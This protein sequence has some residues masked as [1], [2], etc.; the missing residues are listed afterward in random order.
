MLPMRNKLLSFFLLLQLTGIAQ[1]SDGY[2]ELRELS[3]KEILPSDTTPFLSHRYSNGIHYLYPLY[4]AFYREQ[5]LFAKDSGAYYDELS[6][7]LA[8]A[9]DYASVLELE[10]KRM[11]LP[12]DIPYASIDTVTNVI[13]EYADA[14]KYILSRVKKQKVVMLNE[15]H[16]KPLHRA[17]ALSL[18]EDLYKEGFRYLAME[19]LYNY[20]NA[21][22]SVTAVRATTGYYTAEPMAGELVRK[23]LELGYTLVP[24]EDTDPGHTIKQREYT[25]A[26]HL[27]DFLKGKDSTAKMLV[28]AGY[29]HIEE[30]SLD[31]ARI[32]M[33][34][35]FK[36]ITGIDPFTID[37]TQL[38][39][40]STTPYAAV[41]YNTWIKKHPLTTASVILAGYEPFDL[42]GLHLFDL[43]VIHPPTRFSNGRPLWMA[44]NGMKKETP[45]AAPYRSVFMV[46]AYY[47]NEYSEKLVGQLVPSDQTY[48]SPNGL[49]YLYLQKGKYKLVFRDKLYNILGTKDLLSE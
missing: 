31:E 37:Q 9:S 14:H 17:F 29:G 39:E 18:L 38:S 36:I 21:S 49:Y 30:A 40:Y 26:Q 25:Q 23:A 8:T 33:A 28:L 5:Q 27:A 3:K 46:Q 4:K 19:M 16:N 2:R 10:K 24:Y 42:F 15:A 44:V 7:A 1:F 20:S 35:Y 13:S 41:V 22:A 48:N 6:Q 32:P 11:Y 12:D 47:D 43:Q 34:A 45:V